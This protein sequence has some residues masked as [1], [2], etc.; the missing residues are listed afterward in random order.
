MNKKLTVL[1]CGYKDNP[2]FEGCLDNLLE[3]E[4]NFPYD[5]VVETNGFDEE[6]NEI[7]DRYKESFP[8]IFSTIDKVDFSQLS[9]TELY[10]PVQNLYITHSRF[11]LQEY[12]NFRTE[13]NDI[14]VS[15]ASTAYNH[16]N[17][18]GRAIQSIL[19]Q[20]T[21]FKFELI[22][23]EDCS[24][25]KTRRIIEKYRRKYPD[26]IRPIY[27]ERN[28]GL[29]ENDY[30]VR[31]RLRGK[32]RA[33][34]EGDDY[35]LVKDKLQK[36]VDFLENHPEYSAITGEFLTIDSQGRVI[37]RAHEQIYSKTEVYDI[38]EVQK[39]LMPSNT[40][41]LLHRNIY[42][43]WS[44][45]MTYEYKN[46]PI[47]GDRKLHM[48]LALNGGIY[49][50][51]DYVSVRTFRPEEKNSFNYQQKRRNMYPIT[52]I[53]LDEAE[54]FAEK[55]YNVKLDLSYHKIK[56]YVD[57]IKICIRNPIKRNIQAVRDYKKLAHP[58]FRYRKALIKA[59]FDYIG[60]FYKGKNLFRGTADFL[61][62]AAKLTKQFFKRFFSKQQDNTQASLSKFI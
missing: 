2:E 53:W 28:I 55:Y 30:Y 17:Y 3:Q 45:Y 10:Y 20:E 27:N 24:T 37:S 47:L 33:L 7:I 14:M 26:I 51:R 40:L 5:V 9:D 19:V 12:Y 38:G 54:K 32:Y 35:W 56:S 60:K 43:D 41:S 25:D 49:H 31:R 6:H 62:T 59:G 21:N 8:T 11:T 48:M 34:L 39:W 50:S 61:K 42:R 23:G 15:I 44:E 57:C 18:I 22:I 4:V 46:S 52:Y 29:K 36:Q 1:L 13:P 58:D 16:E